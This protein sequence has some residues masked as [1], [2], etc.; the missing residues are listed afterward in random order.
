[1]DEGGVEADDDRVVNGTPPKR[2]LGVGVN[3]TPT[4]NNDVK[5]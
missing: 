2:C 4:L 5:R 1:M 3:T